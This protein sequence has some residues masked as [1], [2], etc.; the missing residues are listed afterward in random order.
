LDLIKR[1]AVIESILTR[2]CSAE[3]LRAPLARWYG[4]KRAAEI[5]FAEAF[6]ICE[7]G[8]QPDEK[9]IRA[10]FPF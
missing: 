5:R 8:R 3:K 7:Y 6:E 2:W 4:E 1:K 9:E 10:L